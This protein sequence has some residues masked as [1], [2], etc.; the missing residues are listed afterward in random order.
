MGRRDRVKFILG[1]GG[2]NMDSESESGSV[3]KP[4]G[5][6]QTKN[7]RCGNMDALSGQLRE[8]AVP[9]SRFLVSFNKMEKKGDMV[10]FFV[11]WTKVD[12]SRSC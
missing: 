12:R 5:S 2:K 10:T 6:R 7:K 3:S 11:K 8:L 4:F 1:H 9:E